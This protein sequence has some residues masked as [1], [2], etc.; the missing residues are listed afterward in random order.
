MKKLL[1][2]IYLALVLM[3]FF[4]CQD[5]DDTE[6]VET[7]EEVQEEEEITDDTSGGGTALI[8]TGGAARISQ[9]LALTEALDNL[10]YLDDLQFMSA[11]SSGALNSIM[12]DAVLD[13]ENGFGWS[14]YKT[15]LLSITTESI[16]TNTTNSLPVDT[17]PL[18]NLLSTVV[19]EQLGYASM[20]DITINTVISSAE[21]DEELGFSDIANLFTIGELKFSSNIEGVDEIGGGMVESLMATTAFPIAFPSVEISGNMYVDGAV[22]ER[23]IADPVITYEELAGVAFDKVYIVSFQRNDNTD[24]DAELEFLGL[25]GVSKDIILAAIEGAGIDVDASGQVNFI[26][27]LTTIQNDYPDLASRCYVYVP[28]VENPDYYGTFDF[29]IL[30]ESYSAAADWAA[31]NEP[32]LLADYLDAL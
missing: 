19:E 15:I 30:S 14:E 21:I 13:E 8:T 1:S 20:S 4:G 7:T 5:D 12:L 9:L 2:F 32:V 16:F 17:E 23:N 24:W 10:G 31:E 18:E 26:E 25:S 22:A 28:N 29:G 3:S 11:V 27:E 6:D